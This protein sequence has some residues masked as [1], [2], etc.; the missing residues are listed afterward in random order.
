M[1]TKISLIGL[2]IMGSAM[3]HNLLKAGYPLTVWNRTPDK[4]EPLVQA[5]A[6]AAG[7]PKEAA[8]SADVVITMLADIQ[9]IQESVFIGPDSLLQGLQAG[10]TLIDSSTVDPATSKRL[11]TAAKERDTQFLDAPVSGSKDAAES[12]TLVYLVGGHHDA[13]KACQ[14]IFDV[15]GSRAFYF[16]SPGQGSTAKLLINLLLGHM[17]AGLAQAM[18]LGQIFRLDLRAWLEA[19]DAGGLSCPMYQAK[20]DQVLRGDFDARFPLKHMQKDLSF[21]LGLAKREAL[22]LTHVESAR[23]LF[24]TAVKQ[25][26]GDQDIVAV[27]RALEAIVGVEVRDPE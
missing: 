25:G 13:F 18:V 15:L 17:T 2:G 5:G 14:P 3:A 19:L 27:I 26:F 8:E 23:Q 9:A 20:G 7:S 4:M 12:G 16:G 24:S 11:F 22:T 1:D 21:V 6:S 10:S